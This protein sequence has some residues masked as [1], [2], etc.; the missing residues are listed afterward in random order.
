MGSNKMPFQKFVQVGRVVYIAKG[1][2]AGKIAAIVDIIDQNRA[3]LDGPCSGVLRQ[4][5][6]FTELHLTNFVVKIQRGTTTKAVRL[7]WVDA[8]VEDK[9]AATS[10]ARR[11]EKR[12]KRANLTDLERFKV[13]KAKSARNKMV[14]T[15]F[16]PML[17]KGRK[18]YENTKK[19]V[20]KLRAK[21]KTAKAS[22]A[23]P[24]EYGPAAASDAHA[25]P[26]SRAVAPAHLGSPPV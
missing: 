16:F 20:T 3:V 22:K 5:R 8:K 19:R 15:A 10:W 13:A 2:D 24:K 17:K 26:Q 7:A 25:P 4:A 12:E 21:A 23:A 9:W 14:S 11:I 1:E 6:R 18:S